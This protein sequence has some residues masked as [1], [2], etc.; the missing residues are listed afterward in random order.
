MVTHVRVFTLIVLSSVVSVIRLRTVG[1]ELFL[2]RYTLRI[3]LVSSKM[4]ASNCYKQKYI[5]TGKNRKDTSAS[6]SLFALL[7]EDFSIY[8]TIKY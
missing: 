2:V 6:L 5:N 8:S 4:T 7:K 3:E 1:L